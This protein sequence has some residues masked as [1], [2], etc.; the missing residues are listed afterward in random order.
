LDILPKTKTRIDFGV[1][2]QFQVKGRAYVDVNHSGTFDPGDVAM[3]KIRLTLSSGQSATTSP[4]GFY[5]F[6]RV[7]PGSNR[8]RIAFE[9]IPVGYRTETAIEKA[10]EAAPGDVYHFDVILTPLRVISGYVFEDLNQNRAKEPDESGIAKVQIRI[11][12]RIVRTGKKG[13]YQVSDLEPGTQKLRLVLESVPEG[14]K[15]LIQEQTVEVPSGPFQKT[16]VQF[17]LRKSFS[18]APA[19]D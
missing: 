16:D 14:Y 18:K 15:P 17:A 8:I 19:D 6:Q 2:A 11:G 10:L 4:D 7:P 3:P 5:N 9:S 12:D 13:R 1:A